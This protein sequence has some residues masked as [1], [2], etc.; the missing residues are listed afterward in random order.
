MI[1]FI[2]RKIIL[3]KYENLK[4]DYDFVL[5]RRIEIKELKEKLKK[6]RKSNISIKTKR[7]FKKQL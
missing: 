1:F 3:K 6:K 5:Y 7:L 2:N 4:K